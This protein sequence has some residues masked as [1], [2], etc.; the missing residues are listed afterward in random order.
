MT[1]LL[2][3][4]F[5]RASSLPESEQDALARWLIRELEAETRWTALLS[6]SADRISNLAAEAREEYK[7]ERTDPAAC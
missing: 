7:A 5:D 1:D 6:R 2:K 4:A 3:K